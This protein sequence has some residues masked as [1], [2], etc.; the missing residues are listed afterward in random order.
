MSY[1]LEAIKKAESERGKPL[2]RT[3]PMQAED[4][5]EK[6]ARSISW[7]AIAVFINAI[8]LLA[9]IVMQQLN[10]IDDVEPEQVIASDVVPDKTQNSV[11]EYQ[12][13]AVDE[14]LVSK[15]IDTQA[16]DEALPNIVSAT[17]SESS[18]PSFFSV[19]DNSESESESAPI[20]SE[21]TFTSQTDN[22]FD[23]VSEPQD[24]A[25]AEVD[26]LP[27]I[28]KEAEPELPEIIPVQER[29]VE[30]APVQIEASVIENPDVPELGELPYSLQQEIPKLQISVHIYNVQKDARKVRVNGGL[31]LEGESI[32]DDLIVREITPRGVVFDYDGTLFKVSLR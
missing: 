5:N 11:Q 22:Q 31:L 14:V 28:Y 12:A 6:P 23:E 32:D 21:Q 1:I 8:I 16:Q 26:P 24:L 13:E 17:E 10:K 27:V 9:W 29:A 2:L 25:K 18:T 4:N 7:L 20:D 3:K 15:S 19:S 30:E